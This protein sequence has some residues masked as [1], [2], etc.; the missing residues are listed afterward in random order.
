[1]ILACFQVK[2]SWANIRVKLI[3]EDWPIDI[4]NVKQT[5]QDYSPPA[6]ATPL[7]Q[8]PVSPGT[9]IAVAVIPKGMAQKV[10]Q[11]AEHAS[12]RG[13]LVVASHRPRLT[14]SRRV[15][16]LNSFQLTRTSQALLGAFQMH[17]D[18]DRSKPRYSSVCV[19]GFPLHGHGSGRPGAEVLQGK[20][21]LL[22]PRRRSRLPV[23]GAVHDLAHPLEPPLRVAD[24]R[25]TGDGR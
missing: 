12:L 3:P 15:H 8:V 25:T 6:L 16:N 9:P 14:A 4:W 13:A 20:R 5:R 23:E 2:W 17:T 10:L 1:M 24:R 11:R 18:K 7:H 19:C 21:N 22:G